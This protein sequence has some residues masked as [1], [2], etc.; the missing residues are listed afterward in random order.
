[1]TLTSK[2]LFAFFVFALSAQSAAASELTGSVS[3]EG[4]LFFHGAQYAGQNDHDASIALNCEYYQEFATGSSF[5]AAPFIRLDRYDSQRTH[6]DLREL[7]YLHLADD[8][9]MKIGISKVF[10]GATEFV[11][12][13]D[14]INQTDLVEDINGEEKLGQ[15]MLH[16]SLSR[17]W[18]VL[19]G[20]I[21][22]FFRERTFPG[23]KGRLRFPLIVDTDKAVYESGAAEYHTDFAL[24]YSQTIGDLDFGLSQFIG[25]TREPTLLK[26]TN[27]SGDDVLSPFYPQIKQTGLD[28]QLVAGNWLWKGEA[29]YRHGQGHDFSAAT[30]GF[31]YTFYN[32]FGSSTDL[33]LLGEYISDG[34]DGELQT[35]YDN[36]MMSGLRWTLND[37]DGSELLAGLARDI[38]SSSMLFSLEG[39]RRFGERIKLKINAVF[40]QKMPE[41]DPFFAL[42]NDDFIKIEAIFYF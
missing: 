31:E 19:D 3:L 40:F 27:S 39:S 7:N 41:K 32:I 15:P 20:F 16:L 9:E 26:K 10:W 2:Y 1:M 11:H 6:A 34:R 23:R 14:I 12:L 17:V 28:L 22:P 37:V 21:L 8:W 29:L 42:Q 18:G 35:P 36:D 24:R 25:T 33:G 4:S 13:I 38:N 30:F 5:T